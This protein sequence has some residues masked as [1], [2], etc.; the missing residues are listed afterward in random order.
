MM[1][2]ES[3]ATATEQAYD[4]IVPF[5]SLQ[6][7]VYSVRCCMFHAAQLER[8]SKPARGSARR[9]RRQPPSPLAM[10]VHGYVMPPDTTA[11]G[12]C[13]SSHCDGRWSGHVTGAP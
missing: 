1:P 7:A 3:A 12:S 13:F 11:D 8:S 6:S 2:D 10:Q 5:A 9:C 4:S